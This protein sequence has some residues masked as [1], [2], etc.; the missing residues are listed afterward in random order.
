PLWNTD[1]KPNQLHS[2][3]QLPHPQTWE[4]H[5]KHKWSQLF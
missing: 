1:D 5:L 4:D 2:L 3:Q